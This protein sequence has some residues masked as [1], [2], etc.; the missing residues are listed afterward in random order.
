MIKLQGPVSI[1][2]QD[3]VLNV[4]RDDVTGKFGP[5]GEPIKGAHPIKFSIKCNVQPIT[6]DELLQLPEG[7]RTADQFNL[8]TYSTP[9]KLVKNDF[10]IRN[11]NK[12]QVQT[13]EDWGD[14]F[15]CR[16]VRVDVGT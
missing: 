2:L 9:K 4:E 7:S 1:I 10:V 12:Y 14:F 16:I 15:K 3:E 5:N 13:V 11:G 6:G 8:F